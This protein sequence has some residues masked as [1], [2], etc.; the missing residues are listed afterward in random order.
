MQLLAD[1]VNT[2]EFH[3]EDYATPLQFT[4]ELLFRYGHQSTGIDFDG[5]SDLLTDLEITA[6]GEADPHAGHNHRRRKRRNADEDY[7]ITQVHK[8]LIEDST[9]A[10]DI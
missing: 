6:S 10:L 3:Y 1:C 5:F 9:K 7:N 8:T 2:D 4:L